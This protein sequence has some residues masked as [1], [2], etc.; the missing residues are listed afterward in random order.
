[1]L[2]ILMRKVDHMQEQMDTI[3]KE[4]EMLRRNQ[5]Q[6]LKIKS[7]LI[8]MNI[9]NGHFVSYTIFFFLFLHMYSR[10]C[11]HLLACFNLLCLAL[12]HVLF[13]DSVNS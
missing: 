5:R 12:L 9:F 11:R 4:V 3:I 2:R 10:N 13:T 7:I 1:M 8:E 6:M